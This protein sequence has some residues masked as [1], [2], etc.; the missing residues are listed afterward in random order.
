[1]TKRRRWLKWLLVATGIA[2]ASLLLAAGSIYWWWF[3]APYEKVADVTYGRRGQERLLLDVFRPPRQNGAGVVVLVSGGWKSGAGSVRPFLFAPFLR[4]GYTVFAVRHISQ[5]ECLIGEIAADVHRAV[6]FIRHGAAG[7]GI[8]RDRIAV[9]GGSSGGHL[10]LLL[11]TCGGPG[12][13]DA[14]D[15]VDRESSAVE[16]VACFYPPT[17]L[18]I[19]GPSTENL[20]DG[21]PPKSFKRGFGPRAETLPEWKVLGRELSPIDHVTANLPPVF[22]IH[23][24]ADTL[25]PVEQSERF[26]ERA[27]AAGREVRLEIRPGKKHG[28]PTMILDIPRFADWIDEH[29]CPNGLPSPLGR[30]A[31][32]GLLKPRAF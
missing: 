1:M 26:A 13:A 3:K 16:C 22:I 9:V 19:L 10:A 21:G 5:P 20:G 14:A 32:E 6:R 29:L 17:V 27:R 11:A 12:P 25:V 31:G 8:D 23:G 30:G 4:R 7:Y 18:L 28:W 24:G 15:P 2:L